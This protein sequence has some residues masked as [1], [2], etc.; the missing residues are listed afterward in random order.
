MDARSFLETLTGAAR[1]EPDR[2]VRLAVVDPAYVAS[3]YPATLPKVTFEG[4]TTLSVRTYACLYSPA[5]GD[6][7]VMLPTGTT[8]AIIGKVGATSGGG[9]TPAAFSA[10][11]SYDNGCSAA[12]A[13]YGTP[14]SRIDNFAGDVV[15]LTGAIAVPAGLGGTL[16]IAT[17]ISAHRPSV[18]RIV[19]VRSGT[20]GNVATELTI[21][22][23]GTLKP[24]A[25]LG[26]SA[27]RVGLDGIT[28]VK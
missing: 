3:S 18:A 23:D 16:S 27:T 13:P 14:G 20:G 19:P 12:G 10:P 25:S 4:E 21:G 15:R 26:A 1:T 28:F 22:T 9:F 11:A 17:L 2:P 24:L 6:R 7:V 8:Y 5:P